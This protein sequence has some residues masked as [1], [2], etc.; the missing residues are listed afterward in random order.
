MA[1]ALG[2]ALMARDIAGER[3]DLEDEERRLLRASED[4]VKAQQKSGMWGSIGKTLGSI[5]AGALG[6]AL[7]G[8][9]GGVLAAKMVGG[10]LGGRLGQGTI[11]TSDELAALR[12]QAGKGSFLSSQ[13]EGL[14]ESSKL[15]QEDFRDARSGMRN[16]LAMSS[17][18]SPLMA[19]GAAEGLGGFG[20]DAL[21]ASGD[22]M[23][24]WDALIS[25]S[26]F[27]PFMGGKEKAGTEA[28][29][30]GGSNPLGGLSSNFGGVFN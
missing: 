21:L 28:L 7:G 10:Y 20:K 30:V 22:K 11:D 19:Y 9:A 3:R 24:A 29:K 18:A 13:R 5:G 15:L 17:V 16:Q 23:S 1:F 14:T 26:E 2:S 27:S 8:P 12:S 4:A 6:T 25:Q